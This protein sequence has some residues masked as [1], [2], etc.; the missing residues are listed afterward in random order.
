MK[1]DVGFSLAN[2]L[3]Q[4]ASRTTPGFA[5]MHGEGD[6]KTVAMSYDHLGRRRTKDGVRAAFW[7][8]T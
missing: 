5:A 7:Y 1:D 2:S 3:N 8:N 6:G 4:Y